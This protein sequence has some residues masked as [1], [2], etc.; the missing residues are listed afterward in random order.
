M[1]QNSLKNAVFLEITGSYQNESVCQ[2]GVIEHLLRALGT[3]GNTEMLTAEGIIFL[4]VRDFLLE[5][6]KQ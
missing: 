5:I 4:S 3:K 2:Q 6:N 1:D